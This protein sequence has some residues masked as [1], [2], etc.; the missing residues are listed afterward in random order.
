MNGKLMPTTVFDGQLEVD[1]DRGVVYFHS[2]ETG[3][4]VLRICGLTIPKN[5]ISMDLTQQNRVFYE[6]Y[7]REDKA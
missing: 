3:A 7:V 2:A 6:S 5:F 1:I 4:T